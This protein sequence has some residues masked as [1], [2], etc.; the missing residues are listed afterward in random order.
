[1]HDLIKQFKCK[2]TNES[3]IAREAD[4]KSTRYTVEHQGKQIEV[5]SEKE[6]IQE[7]T[8]EKDVE[9]KVKAK[10]FERVRLALYGGDR[11]VERNP[12]HNSLANTMFWM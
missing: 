4:F 7:A 8:D 12:W 9:D 6:K 11:K 5:K 2:L 3:R 1:M 10:T